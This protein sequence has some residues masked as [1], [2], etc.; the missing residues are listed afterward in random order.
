MFSYNWTDEIGNE[1]RVCFPN[2]WKRLNSCKAA[3][4]HHMYVTE[5]TQNVMRDTLTHDTWYLVS[6]GTPIAI[7]QACKSDTLNKTDWLISLNEA[8]WNCSNT[9]R[10]HFSKFLAFVT[11]CPYRYMHVKRLMQSPRM[12][13]FTDG[14]LD[15]VLDP[16]TG[17]P[18]HT[19][20]VWR[21]TDTAMRDAFKSV[22]YYG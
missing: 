17:N 18:A 10:Q 4:Y 2:G 20:R 13:F 14:S 6:Y 3:T 16:I 12:H 8:Y 5:H 7:V 15:C 1:H 11:G 19:A 21:I 9:T 22:P